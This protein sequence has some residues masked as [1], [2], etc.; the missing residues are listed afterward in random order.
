MQFVL[1]V[2]VKSKGEERGSHPPGKYRKWPSV[3]GGNALF[4]RRRLGGVG[5]V[6]GGGVD[7]GVDKAVGGGVGKAG[8]DKGVDRAVGDDATW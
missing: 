2:V 8:V 7:S 1:K 5:R 6:V 4:L 3:G